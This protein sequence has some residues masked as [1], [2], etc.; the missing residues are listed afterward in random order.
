MF[1]EKHNM[2]ENNIMKILVVDDEEPIR[3]SLQ[4]ILEE[5]G[6]EVYSTETIQAATDC[7]KKGIDLAIVDIKL[8]DENGIDLLKLL[9][10]ERPQMPVIMISGHGTVALTAQAFKLGA[11]E[12]MEKP[13][14]LIQ[15]KACVRNALDA[16]RLKH[17]VSQQSRQHLP[18]PVYAAPAMKELYRQVDKLA[19]IAE[20]VVIM[21]PS[22]SGKELVARALHYEGTRA[23]GP[24]VATNAASMSVTLAEDELFGHEKGAFTGAHAR[25]TGCIEQANGGTLFLDEIADMDLQIQAKLLRVLESGQFSRLGSTRSVFV[26]VR[27]VAATHKDLD[28][29]VQQGLFRHDLWYRLCAFILRTPSLDKRRDDIPLLAEALLKTVCTDMQL[30]RSFSESAL[31]ALSQRKYT[32]NIR[33]LKHIV[34]RAAVFS[35]SPVIDEQV[36][37]SVAAVQRSSADNHSNSLKDYT[38]LDYKT[39]R[40]KFEKDYFGEVLKKH[41]GNIT[42]TAASIGMAQSNLS[43]K[44]KELGLR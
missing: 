35:E 14:R 22:G 44:L 9:K 17:K 42:A 36:I 2:N 40:E 23:D 27:I 1:L 3:E 43:R 13:L 29:L 30:D 24:F 26:N 32:G 12:F 16:V 7:V 28:T 41:D 31:S 18:Q 11:H 39:A 4:E 8:G 10:I 19:G 33:E 15:V 37:E 5:E 34:T 25:R 21:G 6:Y 38:S 20:P